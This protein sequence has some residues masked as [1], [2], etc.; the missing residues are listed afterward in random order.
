MRCGVGVEQPQALGLVVEGR[1]VPVDRAA[2][3]ASPRS[4]RA[5]CG[6]RCRSVSLVR[7]T[8]DA[9]WSNSGSQ[10][11][12]RRR[13]CCW[14]TSTRSCIG[15]NDRCTSR[16]ARRRIGL[17]EEAAEQI[18]GAMLDRD[19]G[20]ERPRRCHGRL[21]LGLG[22]RLRCEGRAACC[23][24]ARVTPSQRLRPCATVVQ[25]LTKDKR[26]RARTLG[27]ETA[28]VNGCIDLTMARAGIQERSPRPAAAL[29]KMLGAVSAVGAGG[30][31]LLSGGRANAYYQGPLSDHFDGV[32]FFNPSG[33]GPKG[34][35]AFLKWQFG[36]RGEAW[37]ASFPSPLSAGPAAGA[38]RPRGVA[39]HPRRARDL[40]DPDARQE[41]ARRSGL[42][43][44]REPALV[45]GPQARQPARHR[46]RRP[47][48][49]RR[50]ARHPQPLR[51]HGR[52]DDRAAVAALPPAHRHAARQRRHPEAGRAGARRQRRRLGRYGRS[53]RRPRACTSSRR[54]TGR[55]A[56]PA[57][58]CTR[59]GRASWCSPAS[60]RSTASATAASATAR[61]SRASA[62]AIPASRSRSCRSAPTSRAGSCATTT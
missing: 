34:P 55:R 18:D 28:T 57:T 25:I 49:D 46:L 24:A 21:H 35:G 38:L 58:A 30:W 52:G 5:R 40:P 10:R 13:G 51:P 16:S 3:P 50:R 26:V 2:R 43:R 22:P 36:E 53:R 61:R 15:A 23:C 60:A 9:R 7:G 37:P 56:A 29:L 6:R 42:G 14:L 54:C 19:V 12:P 59:C 31:A 11:S 27:A 1:A 4:R 17:E 62:S 20:D 39:R 8:V 32:R 44:A 33:I 45:C 47:A 48:H 41:R